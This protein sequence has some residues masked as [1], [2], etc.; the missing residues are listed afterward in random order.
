MTGRP[1]GPLT[2]DTTRE[3]GVA[4]GYRRTVAIVALLLAI[5]WTAIAHD[6]PNEVVVHMF[7]RPHGE[8]LRVLVRAPLAAMRDVPFPLRGDG[9]LEL[10][11]LGSTVDDA[12][13]LW[14]VNNVALYEEDLR[15]A[16]PTIVAT[17]VSLPSERFDRYDAALTRTLGSPLP[18]TTLLVWRQ[19]MLDALF[20][21][22]IRSERA[23]FAVVPVFARL[24][25]R[26]TTAV[27]FLPASGGERVFELRGDPGL[28]RL[29]PRWHHAAWR[30]VESGFL[31]ILDG[32]DHLLFLF[33]L[34]IPFRR[35]RPLILVVT[36]FTAA[37]SVT[38]IAST[39]G[40]APSGLWFPPLI[41]TLI[42]ASIVYMALENIVGVTHP[43]RRW[44]TAFAFGLVHGFG[45]SFALRETLQFAGTHVV[46]SLLA[47][48]VGVELGQIAVLALFVPLLRL[49]FR[50]VVAERMGTIVLSALVAHTAWHW[51]LDRGHDLRQFTWPTPDV[52]TLALAVRWILGVVVLVAVT[53][54]VRLLGRSRRSAIEPSVK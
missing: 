24:A 31:H 14:L 19:G 15:L 29:D 1:L 52:A 16:T 4:S 12:A 41:E 13:R 47:F 5:P 28:V 48:N 18:A 6:I 32:T 36:A 38:L 33:C 53:W 44:V 3:A 34:V 49:L 39:L 10:S 51:M 40:A 23:R 42:A 7:I 2:A 26:V 37:H 8:R 46:T 27:H 30:F 21:Y 35:S 22:Q 25:V 9:T 50:Y 11:R 17:R 45:F 43:Q 20:E 54:F